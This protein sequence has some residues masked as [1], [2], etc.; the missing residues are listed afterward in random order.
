MA[1]WRLMNAHYLNVSGTEWEHKETDRSTGKQARK[2]FP[3]PMLLNPEDPADHNYPGEIIVAHEGKTA[4]RRDIIF[5]GQP[6]PVV[7]GVH[8]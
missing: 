3:V 4:Q 8:G 7:V 1:R 2:V 5:V 6:S